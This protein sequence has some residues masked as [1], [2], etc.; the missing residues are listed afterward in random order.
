V[1]S[2]RDT[3]LGYSTDDI[4]LTSAFDPSVVVKR[5]Q[6]TDLKIHENVAD[7]LRRLFLYRRLFIYLH[8]WLSACLPACLPICLSV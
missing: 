5:S 8:A 2:C 3:T 6:V 4:L 7:L 1:R